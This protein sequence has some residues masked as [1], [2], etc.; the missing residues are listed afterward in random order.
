[1]M[2][3]P[4]DPNGVPIWVSGTVNARAMQR[5]ARF[6]AGWI[7]W[8]AALESAEDLLEEIPRMREAVARYGRDPAEIQIAGALPLVRGAD[9]APAI[10]PTLERLPAL[11]EAGVTDVRASLPAPGDRHAAEDYLAEWVAAFRAVAG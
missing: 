10:G 9:G 4:V 2:P 6:G 5:L 8:G 11:L 1:M 7:P 3:K